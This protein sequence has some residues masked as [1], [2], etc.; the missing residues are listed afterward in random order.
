MSNSRS[1]SAAAWASITARTTGEVWLLL[2]TITP[3]EDAP[4]RMV[5]S[6]ADIQSRGNTFIAFPFDLDL[7]TDEEGQISSARIVL[8]N[9]SRQL[10]D[11]IRNLP[12][13]LVALVELILESA[14]DVVE[15]SF[16]DFTLKSL[17]YNMITIQGDLS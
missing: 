17:S 2:L 15:A 8:D 11:E 4:I 12:S 7:P 9:V 16:P 1:L 3:G 14:P 13:P 6:S 10:I 5:N